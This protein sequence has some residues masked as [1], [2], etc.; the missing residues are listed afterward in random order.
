MASD[1]G[2]VEY[3][4]DQLDDVGDISFRKMFGEYALYNKGKIVALICDNRLFIKP[5]KAGRLFIGDVVEASPYPGAKPSFLIG[6]RIDDKEW[7]SSLV[8]MTEEELPM[9]KPKKKRTRKTAQKG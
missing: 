1:L 3:V 2:F 4:V 6:E 7:I 8:R 5:T 9:P